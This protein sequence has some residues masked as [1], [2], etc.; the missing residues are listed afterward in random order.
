[1]T[2]RLS[3][4]SLEIEYVRIHETD[5]GQDELFEAL[6][7]VRGAMKCLD[8]AVTLIQNRENKMADELGVDTEMGN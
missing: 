8:E 1:M 5:D 3:D 7:Y 6:G 4:L 2:D